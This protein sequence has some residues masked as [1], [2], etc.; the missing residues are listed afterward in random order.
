MDVGSCVVGPHGNF[1]GKNQFHVS[2][3]K[4]IGGEGFLAYTRN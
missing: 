1:G 2:R 3:N 4:I